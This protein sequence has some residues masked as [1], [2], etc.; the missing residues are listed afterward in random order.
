MM[1]SVSQQ[2]IT[3]YAISDHLQEC[4]VT[5]PQGVCYDLEKSIAFIYE[6]FL[7]LLQEKDLFE[8]HHALKISSSFLLRLAKYAWEL[9]REIIEDIWFDSSTHSILTFS[10]TR[11]QKAVTSCI[12]DALSSYDCFVRDGSGW[13]CL[14]VLSVKMTFLKYKVF[15]G[16]CSVSKLP[17]KF[18]NMRSIIGTNSS[19]VND[20]FV[21]AVL[22]AL[23][24]KI[25]GEK[26]KNRSRWSILCKRLA[27][28]FP[29]DWFHYPVSLK[30]AVAFDKDSSFAL[31][32]FGLVGS[33]ERKGHNIVPYYVSDFHERRFSVDVLFYHDH[34]YPIF[35]L[36][37]LVRGQ[38]RKHQRKLHVCSYCLS[39]FARL[40]AFKVHK[41]LCLKKTQPL[42]FPIHGKHYKKFVNFK[43]LVEVPFVTYADLESSI[44]EKEVDDSAM[45]QKYKQPHKAIAWACFTVC[46]VSPALSSSKP[47]VYVG[48]HAIEYLFSY[49]ETEFFR[50]LNC[51]K[52]VNV[53]LLMSNE[54]ISQF[55]EVTVCQFCERAFT[56]DNPKVRDHCHLSGKYRFALCSICN[57]TYAKTRPKLLVVFHGLSNYDSHFLVQHI[58]KLKRLKKLQINVI[59]RTSEKYLTLSIGG[60]QFKDSYQFLNAP[61]SQL[62]R[63]L[64]D[65]GKHFFVHTKSVYNEPEMDDVIFQKGVF[66][67]SYLTHLEVLDE[68]SLPAKEAFFNDLTQEHIDEE[69]YK[70]AQKAWLVG[71][72]ETLYDYLVLYLTLD[73]LLLADVMENFRTGCMLDYTLDPLQYFSAAHYTFDAYLK[74]SKVVFELLTDVN[75]YFFCLKGL[76]GG[77]SMVSSKRYAIANNKYLDHFDPEQAS[78]YLLDI[79]A[80]NLYG[81]CMMDYLPIGDFNFCFVSHEL[82]EHILS[83]PATSDHGFLLEV[84]LEYPAHLHE[85]HQDYPLAPLKCEKRLEQLSPFAQKIVKDQHLKHSVGFT[86]LMCTLENRSQYVLHYRNLQLYLGLGMKLIKVHRILR[87]K[88]APIMKEYIEFNSQK[89]ALAKNDFDSALYKLLSNSLY[90]KTIE[91]ADNRTMIKLVHDLDQYEKYVSLVTMKSCKVINPDLVSLE[92]KHPLLKINK[93]VYLG[94][95]ILELAKYY[96]YHFHYKVM[97]PFYQDQLK[98]LYT[99]TDSL[100]YEITSDDMYADLKDLSVQ[101]K[102]FDFS[103]YPPGHDLYAVENKRVPGCFKDETKGQVIEKF[104]GLRSKM[105]AI[106]VKDKPEVKAAKGVKKTVIQQLNFEDYVECLMNSKVLEHEYVSIRSV[107]HHVFTACQSKVSL[108][109]F[110]DKRWI[111]KNGIDT[112]PYGMC[113]KSD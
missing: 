78:T 73:V 66:P 39:T 4:V 96:M 83:L 92:L 3:R 103:N 37:A 67:Y 62:V 104:V 94:V 81:R 21:R 5:P 34:Y 16:G 11:A 53:P 14:Q 58:N 1:D 36:G 70:F 105:Y 31:N 79:D 107:K 40:D 9:E 64:K 2:V 43:N 95:V 42:E 20:C 89:R 80:N 48:E 72:C 17:S 55:E 75:Q 113:G 8:E 27:K 15:R 26:Y 74:M 7:K 100:L 109:S 68:S 23:V 52:N 24:A 91:R 33:D 22:L 61:L 28:E 56:T 110:D 87:F 108:S 12:A 106:K 112:I 25:K 19:C 101:G 65:K 88:Q 76:R 93:P 59:P 6:L 69:S 84:D 41:Y 13:V 30:E 38:T 60:L 90:G 44:S 49:L 45:K 10:R 18:R 111:L 71:G 29:V 32:I 99:D 86:K 97:K 51:L 98:L 54:D 102:Y 46:R 82:I 57:L 63:D 85:Q 47:K 77:V 50:V 35:N